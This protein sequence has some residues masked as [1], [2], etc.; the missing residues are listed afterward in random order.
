[1][2]LSLKSKHKCF[3]V[4][5]KKKKALYTR[6]ENDAWIGKTNN[7]VYTIFVLIYLEK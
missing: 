1:M 5:T 7:T 2:D 6:A 4:Y 3:L